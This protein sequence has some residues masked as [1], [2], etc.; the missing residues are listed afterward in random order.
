[1]RL[2]Y[3]LVHFRSPTRIPT[4]VDAGGDDDGGCSV[5]R[6]ADMNAESAMG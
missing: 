1:M 3:P 6:P 5:G 2:L 4:D